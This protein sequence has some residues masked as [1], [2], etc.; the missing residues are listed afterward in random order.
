M[1]NSFALT[2]DNILLV[3]SGVDTPQ[4]WGGFSSQA[5]AAGVLPPASACV[6]AD[7]G[8]GNI[9]GTYT[10]YVRFVDR[11]GLVSDPSPISNEFDAAGATGSVSSASNVTPITITTSAAHGLASGALV[12]I[13]GVQGN[14]GANGTWEITVISATQFYLQDSVGTGDYTTGGTWTSGAGS[15]VYTA[16]P[17]PVEPKVVRRQILRNTDGQ[18]RVWYV[19]VDT[20][21]LTSAT[22]SSTRTDEDLSAQEAVVFVGADGSD[23][24]NRHTVPPNWKAFLVHHQDRM[25]YLG[26]VSYSEGNVAMTAGSTTVTGV[27]TEWTSALEGRFLYVDGAPKEFE[28]DSVDVGAQTLTLTEPYTG[29]TSAY[30]FYAIRPASAE[31]RLV[32]FSESGL[33]ESVP[34]TN[35]FE[36][37]EDGDDITGGMSLQSFLYVL[38]RRHIYRVSFQQGPDVDGTTY[39]VAQRGSVNHRSF[40]QVDNVAYIMDERGVYAFS[41]SDADPV[42]ADIQGLFRRDPSVPYAINWTCQRFFHAHQYP[43]DETIRWFVSLSGDYLP[44]HALCYAYRLKRWTIEEF[45]V[46]I[47]A[48]CV[49]RLGPHSGV[50]SS[51]QE[52]AYLGSAARRILAYGAGWLDGPSGSGT[53]LGTAT[54]STW[55]SLTDTG[56]DFDG[57]E[58]GCPVSILSGRGKGQTRLVVKVSGQT[59]TFDRPLAVALDTTSKY[60]VGSVSWLWR[61]GLSFYGRDEAAQQ[62]GWDVT[63]RPTTQP[64]WLDVRR[65]ID[66]SSE[67]EEAGKTWAADEQ[68]GVQTTDGEPD[69]VVDL[70]KLNGYA[71][72]RLIG[73]RDGR[74]DKARR[75]RLEVRGFTGPEPIAIYRVGHNGV[76]P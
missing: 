18:A 73:H 67:P 57:N 63:F 61:S 27:A 22:F 60:R 19:D 52:Q 50:W 46:P 75:A 36:I 7:A 53:T 69:H 23:L 21:N 12:K 65:Y 38:E 44:R 9:V 76:V 33:P 29:P 1:P 8:L 39:L 16:V 4:R 34:A 2:P 70:T 26:E 51:G 31:R 28:I 24:A 10:A 13:E 45:A 6:I 62:R 42:S 37:Q 5:E 64:A 55:I 49:G 25:F 74:L 66:G 48:S 15:I 59:L 43:G 11:Y 32:Y 30:S 20:T 35:A 47:S 40:V 54:S 41:G 58:V 17:L 71:E 72:K 3:T 56:A 14:D 68:M